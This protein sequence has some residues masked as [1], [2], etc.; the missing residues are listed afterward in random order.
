[1][2]FFS[3]KKAQTFVGITPETLPHLVNTYVAQLETEES[4]KW[5]KCL[6]RVHPD[7][8]GIKP[9]HC[10]GCGE[11]RKDKIHQPMNDQSHPFYGVRKVRVDDHPLCPVHTKEGLIVGFVEWLSDNG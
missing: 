5:C 1:M 3:K 4:A 9:G 11:S 2:R 8:Q 7:D 6:W 10:R